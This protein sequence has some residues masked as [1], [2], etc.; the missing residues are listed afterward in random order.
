MKKKIAVAGLDKKKLNNLKKNFNRFKF[1][2]ISDKNFFTKETSNISALIIYAEWPVKKSLTKYLTYNYN[3]FKNIEWVHLSRAGIDEFLSNLKK[4]TF[5]F[6]CGKI[7][8]GPNVSEHCL[9]LLLSLTRGMFEYDKK[10]FRPTEVFGKKVLIVGLGG[11]G[12]GVAEKISAFGAKVYGAD[13]SLKPYFSFIEKNYQ[14]NEINK[15]IGKFDIVINTTPLT[16]LTKNLFD[17]KL[18]SKMK[19]GVFF[20]NVSRGG[21]VNTFDLKNYLK[22]NKF[23]A[24]GLDII[25]EG[26]FVKKNPLKNFK[27]V[28]FTNHM[29]GITT[30]MNR[31]LNLIEENIEKYSKNSHLLNQIDP[32][33]QY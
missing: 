30:D 25:G 21:I 6:T 26:E 5:K 19:K 9:A 18:F 1:I 22:K 8:Q 23:S 29:A 31:R 20:V 27:N 28:I 33:K 14:I 13:S 32:I 10:K 24:V 17:K 3:F 7:I 12:I 16:K 11:I 15:I 4:Y 2:D